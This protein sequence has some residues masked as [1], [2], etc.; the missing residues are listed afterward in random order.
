M[1]YAYYPGCSADSTAHDLYKATLAVARAL[2]I[3]LV[4]PEG[5]T[6]C[7]STMAH[8]TNPDLSVALAAASLLKVKKMGLEMVVSCASCYSRMK[9]ANAEIA[10]SPEI[11]KATA[12][13]LGEDYDGSVRVRHFLEIFLQDIGLDRLRKALTATLGGMKVASYYGCLLVRPPEITGFDDPEN[14]LS[15]DRLIEVMGGESL[16]WPAKVDCCGG[17]LTLTRTDVVVGL[18]GTILDMAKDSGADCIAV[19]CPMCQINLDLRQSDIAA[20]TGRNYN[21]PILYL[22]QLMGICLGLSADALGMEKLIVPPQQVLGSVV[23]K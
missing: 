22:P 21:L 1:K 7:G 8:Q 11:R 10:G 19:A 23:R 13:A 12:T 3:D 2:G 4:E 16:D 15:M 5:W 6:C 17:S 18:S 20:V 14:P 9:I